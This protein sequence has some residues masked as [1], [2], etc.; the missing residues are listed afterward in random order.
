MRRD[1]G[2]HDEKRCVCGRN[3]EKK[4]MCL[5]LGGVLFDGEGIPG[6]NPIE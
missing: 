3:I 1:L 4:A 6:R 5:S 2:S